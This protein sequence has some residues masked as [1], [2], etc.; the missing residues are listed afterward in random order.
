MSY[1][2]KYGLTLDPQFTERTIQAIHDNLNKWMSKPNLI[3][4]LGLIDLTTLNATDTPTKVSN[5]VNKVNL[6]Q[7]NF[8]TFYFNCY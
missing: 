8:F 4:M 3:Q 5:L 2:N 6:F 7:N 1:L